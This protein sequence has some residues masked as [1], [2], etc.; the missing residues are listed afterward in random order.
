M[1]FK[2]IYNSENDKIE[3]ILKWLHVYH[4]SLKRLSELS[5]GS[6]E[7]LIDRSIKFS[8]LLNGLWI[9]GVDKR[10]GLGRLVLLDEWLLSFIP[11]L[12]ASSI[13]ILDVGGSDGTTT[14]ELLHFLE[15][16]LRI[17]IKAAILERQLRLLCFRR[18]WMRYY[19]TNE[20]RPFILQ[21]GPFGV[22]LEESK[23]MMQFII[24]PIVRFTQ[25]C[26]NRLTLEKYMKDEG[27]LIL[28]S[29]LVREI[30][31]IS[32]IEQDLTKFNESLVGSFNIIRCCNILN[33]YYFSEDQ[34][35]NAVK[36]LSHYLM[37]NGLLLVSRSLDKTNGPLLTASIWTKSKEGLIHISDLNGGSEIKELVEKLNQNNV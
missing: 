6:P 35:L 1:I 8:S 17:E 5:E 36:L 10:T 15:E 20:K 19:K 32:W 31:N 14:F 16:N 37:P 28:M 2:V 23:G 22:L 25:R 9:G 33:F 12:Q 4:P 18:G 34:I 26:I 11:K 30:A 13:S 24:N 29:P 3:A 7:T 21:V 27:D